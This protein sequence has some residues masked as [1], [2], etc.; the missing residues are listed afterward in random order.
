MLQELLTLADQDN[1]TKDYLDLM[2]TDLEHFRKEL[3]LLT[4]HRSDV[5]RMLN[6]M[7]NPETGEVTLFPEEGL[8]EEDL[9]Y[10]QTELRLVDAD[11]DTIQSIIDMMEAEADESMRNA[12]NSNLLTERQRA[13][14]IQ[15]ELNNKIQEF[16]NFINAVQIEEAEQANIEDGETITTLDDV[17]A[18]ESQSRREFSPSLSRVGFTKTQGNHLAALQDW[19]NT[20]ESMIEEG[21]ALTEAEQKHL[22]HVKAQLRF[23]ELHMM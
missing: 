1:I 19:Q 4:Q 18:I 14:G 13:I 21:A 11:I 22:E 10:L 15:Q 23:L 16:I 17:A 2:N 6:K 3:E 12:A 7:V 9:R 8:T 5:E 20:Y